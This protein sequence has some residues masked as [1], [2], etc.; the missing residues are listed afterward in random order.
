MTNA[1]FKTCLQ[2]RKTKTLK[3][4]TGEKQK[5]TNKNK[6]NNHAVHAKGS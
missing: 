5:R 2:V 1:C 3:N 6:N 4:Q